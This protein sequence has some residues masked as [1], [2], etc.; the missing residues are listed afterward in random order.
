GRHDPE[1]RDREQRGPVRPRRQRRPGGPGGPVL[2]AEPGDLAEGG[3]AP[4]RVRVLPGGPG[5]DRPPGGPYGT[6][7]GHRTRAG[8]VTEVTVVKIATVGQIPEGE[9]RRFA[10]DGTEVAVANLGDGEFRG[11]AAICSHAHA[12][13][14]EGEDHPD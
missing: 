10:Y 13:L 3:R 6:G 5:T 1:P 2:P 4:D 14:A 8:T 7:A 11:V 12:Y 9:A